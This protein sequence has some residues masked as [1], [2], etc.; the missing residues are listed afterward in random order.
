MD[1]KGQVKRVGTSLVDSINQAAANNQTQTKGQALPPPLP[2]TKAASQ[3]PQSS[4]LQRELEN[5]LSEGS[6]KTQPPPI[7]QQVPPPKPGPARRGAPPPP[8]LPS[9]QEAKKPQIETFATDETEVPAGIRPDPRQ[10]QNLPLNDDTQEDHQRRTARRRPAGPSRERIAANDD[11][12]SIGGLI[13]ALNQR[14]SKKPFKYAAFASAVWLITAVGFAWSL[15]HESIDI[16]AG[17]MGLL[18]HP[19][20]PTALATIFGPIV[21]FWCLAL[22]IWRSEELHL[23]SSAM[24]EVAVRLAEPD[25]MAEQSVASLGQA[26]RRQ[27]SFMNDAVS[28]ALG[29]AGE[30]EALV[31]NEVNTLEQSYEENERKIRALIKELA[32]ERHALQNTGDGFKDTLM[33]LG[34]E[35]PQ[36]IESLSKQQ[37]KLAQ[38]IEHAGMNLSQLESAIGGQA[39]KLETS[40][41]ENTGRLQSLLE[42]YTSEL[43]GSIEQI[44][45]R[46]T[47]S[48]EK[49]GS[50]LGS[51]IGQIETQL[52][53]KMQ[54]FQD[55]LGQTAQEIDGTLN[56]TFQTVDETLSN[57]TETMQFILEEYA[58]AL[59]MTLANRTN[60]FDAQLV[61]RTK[62]LDEAFSERLRLFDEAIMRSTLSLDKTVNEN[63]HSLTYTL[64]RHVE[65][66]N[67]TMSQQT[68]E[69]DEKLM[70]GI[71]SVRSTSENISRQSIKAIEG[72]AN[73]SEMLRRVSEGVLDQLNNVSDNFENQ[74]ST[75]IQ[76]AAALEA[77]NHRIDAML[78]NR[79]AEINSTLDQLSERTEELGNSF[80]S[81]T[82]NLEGSMSQAQEHARALTQDLTRQTEEHAQATFSKLQR[83]KADASREADQALADLHNEFS[84][85]SHEV[86]NRLVALSDQFSQATGEVRQRAAVAAQQLEEEQGRLKQ[87]LDQL[88]Q[89]TEESAAAMRKALQ[90]QLKA[91]DQLTE[92]ANRT[93]TQSAAPPPNPNMPFSLQAEGAPPRQQVSREQS[94]PLTTLTNTLAREMNE[95]SQTHSHTA[96]Q[97][98]PNPPQYNRGDSPSQNPHSAPAP[99]TQGN[100]YASSNWS[101]GELLSRVPE[102]EQTA[103]R[104]A[105]G[106]SAAP[107]STY[108]NQPNADAGLDITS[109]SRALE[110]S[111]AAAIW[112]RFRSGQRGFMVRSIYRPGSRQLFD[113]I[114]HRYQNQP[115][116]RAS[117]DR[118]VH[119]FEQTLRESDRRDPSGDL[120]QSNI[121]A[122]AG[123]AY[124][125]LAHASQRLV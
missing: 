125:L 8:P 76:S 96:G 117:V 81:Y 119:G 69:L 31:H 54:Q 98:T 52:G 38:I 48:V 107:Q 1:N 83:M 40:L 74:S 27:V 36:L 116:F 65:N 94:R 115:Q 44:D 67:A 73:Q 47:Q 42:G 28:R 85:V 53:G 84:S 4:S 30:L 35:V 2:N 100:A 59:D 6:G 58:R 123:R 22:L 88:P 13:Y 15:M 86:T 89:A 82:R 41:G 114:V 37:L 21:L 43:D 95:R 33:Q 91:L 23:R 7:P 105:S 101:F 55:R 93:S 61:E 64:D 25:R 3:S 26:V 75:I 9:S 32:G 56:N 50:Q 109:I 12:P 120:T 51:S 104:Q 70:R 18:T 46:L 14:P 92:L 103:N 39:E 108:T 72:L 34:S 11:A 71:Q 110:A 113:D 122:E 111:T 20:L 121:T 45:N 97:A 99:Q 124:L 17:L 112:S 29:R 57:R 16:S 80:S 118:F 90:D 19:A 66:L 102:E 87:Q 63:A 78:A 60:L 62:A 49:I 5:L 68:S 10:Q 77:A 24:T 79:S 106:A